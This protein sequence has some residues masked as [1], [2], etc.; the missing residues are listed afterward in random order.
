MSDG[1]IFGQMSGM[2]DALLGEDHSIEMTPDDVSLM[3]AL[4][5]ST[6]LVGFIV[7]GVVT[8]IFGRR[9]ALTVL[10]MPLAVC[11]IVVYFTTTKTV[12]LL[13]R[14]IVGV[15]FGGVLSIS[16]ICV[17]EYAPPNM[18]QVFN[19]VVNGVGSQF[20]SAL[21]H[22]LSIFINWRI[23]ALIGLLPA[24]MSSVIPIFWVESPSWL[25][26]KGR[27]DECRKAYRS[28]HAMNS[29]DENELENLI[30]LEKKKNAAIKE[31]NHTPTPIGR[32]IWACKQLY[33]WKIIF[34]GVMTNIYRIAAMRIIFNT[35]AL[36]ILRDL[37]GYANLW[38]TVL[39]V[40]GFGLIGAIISC[41]FVK[42]FKLRSL[43]F[44]L[45]II[46]NIVL[47]ILSIV[48]YLRPEIDF[49]MSWVKAL[50]LALYLIIVNSGP[51][52]ALETLY[53]E[54][55]PLEIKAFG[56]F[57]TATVAGIFQ[58]LAVKYSPG[59]FASIG[60][61]AVF[62]IYAF[63]IFVVL[64][65]L[66]IALPETKGQTLQQIESYFH[67]SAKMSHGSSNDNVKETVSMLENQLEP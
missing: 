51:Y 31:K 10:T 25:A 39:L 14:L 44:V 35:M 38:M 33:V 45:G 32:L 20:G 18:R 28:L 54:I 2:I 29:E 19:N 34:L 66:W 11:W 61:H 22:I 43:L 65:Y 16:F 27:F 23:V 64:G 40:D 21:G 63:I 30:A 15:T 3:A 4:I 55:Y 12:L 26:S 17:G 6:C 24:I 41:V 1:F 67:K 53:T 8:E 7:A 9:R 46:G 57:V 59:L 37:T 48:L 47:I 58:F 62:L 52:P 36:T 50:L 5:N 13:T 60:Y 56:I 42:L 49:W